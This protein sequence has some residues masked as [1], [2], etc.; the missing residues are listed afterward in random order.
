MRDSSASMPQYSSVERQWLVEHYLRGFQAATGGGLSLKALRRRFRHEFQKKAPVKNAIVA[1]VGKFRERGSVLNQNRG[2]SGRKR[3]VRT[4]ENTEV[5][6]MHTIECPL[7]STRVLASEMNISH[8]SVRRM[9][10]DT[11]AFSYRLQTLQSLSVEDFQARKEFCARVLAQH[12]ED[13]SFLKNWWWS[14]ECHVLLS[15]QEN[16]QNRRY[17]GWERPPVYL[18]S[19][20]HSEKVTVWIAASSHGIIGPYFIEDENRANVTV[21]SDVYREQIIQRF[22]AELQLFCEMEGLDYQDQIFQQDG[23]PAHSSLANLRLLK[24]LFPERLVSRKTAFPWPARSPD[25]SLPDAYIW[26]LLKQ[27]CWVPTPHSRE[28]LRRNICTCIDG[29]SADVLQNMVKNMVKRMELCLSRNG[30]H[31]EHLL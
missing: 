16:R 27:D 31:F 26:G 3:T 9:I 8:T 20:L 13:E 21:T 1:M 25:L 22:E 10:K 14:D 30:A 28:E 17:R 6:A 24:E 29:I 23:A 7:K 11:W 15:G 4:E 5:I 18:E 19:P 12:Y 2:R